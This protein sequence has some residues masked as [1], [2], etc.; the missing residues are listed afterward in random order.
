MC[1][2]FP[3]MRP[4]SLTCGSLHGRAGDCSSVLGHSAC[5][6]FRGTGGWR[7]G[8]WAQQCPRFPLQK[9]RR[10]VLLLPPLSSTTHDRYML[11]CIQ[12]QGTTGH[13][14]ATTGSLENL[15]AQHLCAPHTG[16]EP[17]TCQ[18]CTTG[19]EPPCARLPCQHCSPS[20]ATP[21]P[22]GLRS[23]GF[24]MGRPQRARQ[25]PAPRSPLLSYRC[26]QTCT[27]TR[28]QHCLAPACVSTS[29]YLTARLGASLSG[30]FQRL[31]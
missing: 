28:M 22:T 1:A 4:E 18:P 10:I 17:Q 19:T 27:D 24:S 9:K 2:N 11:L 20:R 31:H 8:C 30:E 26:R 15:R 13:G 5:V 21:R 6:G 12:Q 3:G 14:A 7:G 16:H 29:F 23:H 25:L